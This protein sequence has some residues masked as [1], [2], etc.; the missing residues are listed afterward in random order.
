MDFSYCTSIILQISLSF[1][2]EDDPTIFPFASQKALSLVRSSTNLQ[3]LTQHTTSFMP[4]PFHL[5]LSLS[6]SASLPRWRERPSRV[7]PPTHELS[8]ST[9]GS[10][11]AFV[12]GYSP[13]GNDVIAC[14]FFV[15]RTRTV[16]RYSTYKRVLCS[17]TRGPWIGPWGPCCCCLLYTALS[18]T[19]ILY[20]TRYH[21]LSHTR[22]ICGCGVLVSTF[23]L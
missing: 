15:C 23:I 3:P 19:N 6:I 17:S 12:R 11:Y 7:R 20:K 2:S 18:Y 9:P 1:E 22:S 16:K 21:T 14:S 4:S 8:N 10:R 5:S 13:R